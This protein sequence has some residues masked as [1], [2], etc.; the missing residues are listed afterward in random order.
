MTTIMNSIKDVLQ[1]VELKMK[2]TVE[3]VKREFSTVRTGHASSAL[4]EGIMVDYYGQDVPLR[5]LAGISTP[6]A[7]LILIQPWDPKL[8][9]EIE[10]AVLKSEIGI[11]PAN[12]GKVI[13]LSVPPPTKERREELIKLVKKM[14]EDGKI[15]IR[16]ARH[17][18]IEAAD[19]MEKDKKITEDEKFKA[20]KD[21]QG[22]TD[23][24]GKE[25]D[26]LFKAKEKE[27]IG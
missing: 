14:E 27:I 16:S 22:L 12:D 8:L 18:A 23:K 20:H 7:K 4:V 6:D 3:A 2:K 19:K 21:I 25:I 26:T 11:T 1:D 10:R 17:A 15:S 13:R 9:G 24:H 5:Q